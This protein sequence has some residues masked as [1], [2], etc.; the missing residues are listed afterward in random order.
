MSHP[1]LILP[2]DTAPVLIENPV[3]AGFPLPAGD[4]S[5]RRIDLNAHL[6]I[7]PETSFLFRVQGDSMTDAGIFDG[8]TIIVDRAIEALHGHIVLAVVDDAF[9]VKRLYRKNGRIR[10][11]PENPNHAPIDFSGEQEL[12]IWGVVTTSIRKLF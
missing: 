3:S 12:R 5:H 6:F 2:G 11:M 8:D 7:H 10:L 9:T 4:Q 1:I